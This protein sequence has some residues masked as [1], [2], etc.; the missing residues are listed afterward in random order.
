M[1]AI[2]QKQPKAL[3]M[4]FFAEMWE[5]FSFYGM[6]ALLIVF[7]TTKMKYV[8]K[9][10]NLILG[11]YLALVYALPM[12]G[13]MLADRVLGYR[14]AILWG[15]VTMAMGHFV[16]AIPGETAFF[17]GLGFIIVGNGFFKPN[18]S[19]LVGKLYAEGDS[20]RDSGF[21]IFY[22]GINIG[23][24]LGSVLC[25]WVG[26]SVNWHLGFGLA[27]VF[28]L[29]GLFTFLK[30]QSLL[31][32]HGYSPVP[33]KLSAKSPFGLSTEK[34]IYMLSWLMIPAFVMLITHHE[35]MDFIMYPLAAVAFVYLAITSFRLGKEAGSKLWAAT[36]LVI[37]SVMFWT[38][39]EQGGGSLNLFALRNVD[40]NLFGVK[41][42]STAVNNF[43][44]PFFIVTLGAV[45]TA[46]WTFL[47][48]RGWEPNTPVKFGLAFIQ[49]GLGFYMFV[50][51]AR[52]AVDTGMV[53]LLYFAGG[54]L[55]LSTGELCI[56]PIG[57][58]MIS[59]LTPG[60]M[61]G[62]LMGIWFLASAMGQYFAGIVGTW[63]AIPSENGTA[64]LPPVESLKI[65]SGVFETITNVT[66][67]SGGVILLISPLI[68]RWMREVR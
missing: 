64:S 3:Y 15:G 54:Y 8:D 55:F 52:A 58:S 59:K 67:C 18:I 41:L 6:K 46:L 14:K 11:A 35:I 1:N 62:L 61:V 2:S 44:N 57:L 25:G 34:L 31:E 63:M 7:M 29:I 23:A 56:S 16:L 22:M 37:C 32:D 40:M 42:P 43:I 33:E 20:R 47:G 26:Q 68:R 5:R 28:M 13:G 53:S 12:F 48:K 21:V 60:R 17:A 19:S 4:L 51:G 49:L 27:G 66:V 24:A 10:A 65:Y 9:E 50:L 39:F 36:I 38:F 45:F 30:F